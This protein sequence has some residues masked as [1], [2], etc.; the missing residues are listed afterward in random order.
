MT[1]PRQSWIALCVLAAVLALGLYVAGS[2]AAG[3]K[4]NGFVWAEVTDPCMAAEAKGEPCP[5]KDG[6]SGEE[7]KET[8]ELKP[9]R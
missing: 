4:P 5:G 6:A 1:M 8:G 9:V 2:P 7:L 3:S